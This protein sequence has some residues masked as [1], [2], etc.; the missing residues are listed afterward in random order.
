MMHITPMP[1]TTTASR[2]SS[3]A[4]LLPHLALLLY[5]VLAWM[6]RDVPLGS[7]KDEARYWQDAHHLT[8]GWFISSSDPSIINGPGY[9]LLLT[10]F[11]AMDAPG[12]MVRM[13][14]AVFVALAVWFLWRAI[15]RAA[16]PRWALAGGLLLMFHP[17]LLQEGRF[18]MTEALT[19]CCLC[20]FLWALT[21]A[22]S[23]QDRVPARLLLAA[24]ALAWLTLTRVVFGHVASAMLVFTLAAMLFAPRHHPVLR[25]VAG[26]FAL[27]LLLCLPYLLYTR[28]KTG[29]FPVWATTAPELQYWLTSTYPGENGHW[30]SPEQVYAS[31]ELNAH[32]GDFMR[33]VESTPAPREQELYAE[34]RGEH[35]RRNPKGVAVNWAC[36]VTRLFFGFPRSLEREKLSTI[37]YIIINGPICAAAVLAL[38]LAWKYRRT[39][40]PEPV[41]LL[42]MAAV[43]LGGSTLAPAQPRYSMT[44]LPLVLYAVAVILPRGC[45]VTFA[46]AP[47]Q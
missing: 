8:Q 10:P 14:N 16:G 13:L 12:V 21:V 39:L 46:D 42:L 9:P 41:L 6:T 23:A 30:Y 1:D 17:S 26:V 43:F 24:F 34:K 20:G 27:S 7:V 31:P 11:A 33:L 38:L 29:K 36:N 5:A 18:V 35:V 44:V 45:R 4:W 2:P 22:V 19:V 32:H 15:H 47:R 37:G 3:A 28:A 40:P 25:R